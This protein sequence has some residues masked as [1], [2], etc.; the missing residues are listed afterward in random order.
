MCTFKPTDV[1]ATPPPKKKREEKEEK[2]AKTSAPKSVISNAPTNKS[3]SG[4]IDK[5]CLSEEC[6]GTKIT[7]RNW[8]RHIQ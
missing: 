8:S 2:K 5:H 3:S 4:A 7:G 6:G 1:L